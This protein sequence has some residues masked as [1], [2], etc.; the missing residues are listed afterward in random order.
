M[1]LIH[2]GTR[3]RM[4]SR[5][6]LRIKHT[7]EEHYSNLGVIFLLLSFSLRVSYKVF[8]TKPVIYLLQNVSVFAETD[9]EITYTSSRP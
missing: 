2:N 9:E 5:K 4:L 1:F 6:D 3:K 7:S 8:N